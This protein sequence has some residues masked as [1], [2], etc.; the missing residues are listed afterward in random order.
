MDIPVYESYIAIIES[1]SLSKA[2]EKLHMAQPALSRHVKLL[3]NH[4]GTKLIRTGHGI[5]HIEVTPAGIILYHKARYLV[6][7]EKQIREEINDNRAGTKG[8]LR[9]TTSPSVAFRLIAETLSGFHEKYPKV[10]FH[11]KECSTEQQVENLTSGISEIGIANAPVKQP[12]LFRIH[13]TIEDRM[14]LFVNRKSK[15]LEGH[16][17][18]ER[19]GN[20]LS[21][22]LRTLQHL[23]TD[24]PL[25]LT[26]GCE[27]SDL[28]FLAEM[29]ISKSPL[30][31]STTKTAALQ[32]VR[33]NQ[34]AVIAP[35]DDQ[36]IIDPDMA[37]F[38]LPP[39]L[40]TNYRTVY[41]LKDRTL[42]PLASNF[43][44]FLSGKS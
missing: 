22:S 39:S 15:V 3:E 5:R 29:G 41:S 32:W 44:S 43:I 40:I 34:A 2:A 35:V 13:F 14:V 36:E 20:P 9:L 6:A 12:E 26:A 31:V 11:L 33:Q 4:Y 21:V 24:L 10:S 42:S 17:L 38:L 18:L 37:G 23:L 19:S 30:S 28:R 16:Q 1:G 25:C 7:I 8:I 27:D